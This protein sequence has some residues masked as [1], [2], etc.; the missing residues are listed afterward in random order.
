[1]GAFLRNKW[2][3]S[4][5]YAGCNTPIPEYN[6]VCD[7]AAFRT[8]LEAPW[9]I[10]LTPLD[11]CGDLVL[12]GE[13]HA[14]IRNSEALLA[15]VVMENYAA[16]THR[17]YWPENESSILFDTVAVYLAMDTALCE[18][19]DIALSVDDAGFT[20]PDPSGRV[21]HC[22]MGWKDRE[23]FDELLVDSLTAGCN[24]QVQ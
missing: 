23:S 10:T 15:R 17:K 14:R 5:E 22:Q 6:V 1:V 8:L 7:I 12:R 16:W 13:R 3:E 4:P 19:R 9:D 24:V 11:G 18:M 2:A 21:V 20:V